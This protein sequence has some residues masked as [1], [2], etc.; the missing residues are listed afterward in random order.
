MQLSL[1]ITS[2]RGDGYMRATSLAE[3][4]DDTAQ[5]KASSGHSRD[6]QNVRHEGDKVSITRWALISVKIDPGPEYK[7]SRDVMAVYQQ[8]VRQ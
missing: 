5:L 1:K 6:P 2:D 8:P 4:N 7:S 3:A